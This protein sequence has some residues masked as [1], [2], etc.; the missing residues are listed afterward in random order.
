[1][2]ALS[3]SSKHLKGLYHRLT[4]TL[5]AAEVPIGIARVDSAVLDDDPWQQELNKVRE[6]AYQT[7]LKQSQLR[8]VSE[9]EFAWLTAQPGAD[10]VFT[11]TVEVLPT[12]DLSG[13]DKL[14]IECPDTE[15]SDSDVSHA[16]ELLRDE[17]K[18]FESVER[19]AQVGDRVVFDYIGTIGGNAFKGSAVDGA[20]AVIGA[21]DTLDELDSALIGRSAGDTFT[22][23]IT[24]PDDY[25]ESELR[26]KCAQF[27][28]VIQTVSEPRLPEPDAN[29]VQQVGLS[30]DTLDELRAQLR[31]HLEH[32]CSQARHRYIHR[33]LSQGLL[34]TVPVEVPETLVGEEVQRIRQTFESN[35][36]AGEEPTESLPEAPL[37][38]TAKRRLALSLILSEVI[39]Q[40]NI[41]LDES[42]VEKKL[43]ELAAR[44]GEVESV[45]RRYRADEQ[46]M[47]NV[48]AL[49][50]EEAGFGAAL[51]M[52]SKTPVSLS[53]DEL[54]RLDHVEH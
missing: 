37:E 30:S 44:Y 39:K 52:V 28:I 12:V 4:V 43:E 9:P 38:A 26:G 29:F 14:V 2:T 31:D 50:M 46:V 13:L 20:S 19:P 51:D 27:N 17:H 53:L 36:A 41:R 1:M 49:V 22:I 42:K 47:Q 8:V 25:A 24:F 5:P 3:V 48:R 6:K 11:A 34:D 10:C 18:I 45:K 7:A 33:Q 54:L 16:L 32:E 40:A 21:G 15:V 23:P 35:I